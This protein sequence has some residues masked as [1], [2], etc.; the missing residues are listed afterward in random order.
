M[1]FPGD[2]PTLSS[3]DGSVLLRAH[4]AEDAAGVIEMARDPQTQRWTSLPADYGARHA[5]QHLRRDVPMGWQRDE[6]WLFAVEAAHPDGVRRFA[7]TV[8]LIDRGA[9]RAEVTYGAHPAVR[10]TGVTTR[11]VGL[12]LDWGFGERGLQAVEWVGERGNFASRR[13]AWRLGFF[14]GGM[15]REWLD[16]R[17]RY[18]DAWVATLRPGDSREPRGPWLR[19]P[20]LTIRTAG[21]EDVR[22]RA[23]RA[24]DAVRVAE[25]C[26][27]PRT[28][29]W[30]P[31]LPDPYTEDDARTFALLSHEQMATGQIVAWVVVDHRDRVLANIAVG[32]SGREIGYW[33]HPQARGRG[34]MTAATR[35]VIEHALRPESD[36]GLGMPT[37]ALR[38]ARENTA[39]RR[40]AEAAGMTRVGRLRDAERLRD[41][42]VTD[43]VLYECTATDLGL[44]PPGPAPR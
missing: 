8:G 5:E 28:R 23:I 40:V 30:L 37:V 44:T 10:G 32:T 36:G 27:D 20:E 9:R 43:F 41:G 3:K 16:H 15:L 18:P 17:D 13:V 14:F 22:M 26:S 33:A 29:R 4:R 11:A 7:G 38:A 34:V 25:A 6:R 12:L 42:T 21:G 31:D 1:R 39:S 35:A 24:D 2:V 19:A